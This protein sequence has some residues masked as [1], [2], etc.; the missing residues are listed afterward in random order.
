MNN[1]QAPQVGAVGGGEG[2]DD[3]D[4][5]TVQ[6]ATN[7]TDLLQTMGEAGANALPA[8]AGAIEANPILEGIPPLPVRLQEKFRHLH[9]LRIADYNRGFDFRWRFNCCAEY[10]LSAL[11]LLLGSRVEF[12]HNH[13]EERNFPLNLMDHIAYQDVKCIGSLETFDFHE[14]LTSL[15]KDQHYLVRSGTQMGAGHYAVLTC[16][17]G[18]WCAISSSSSSPVVLSENDQT[19]LENCCSLFCPKDGAAWGDG[20]ADHSILFTPVNT[21]VLADLNQQVIRQRQRQYQEQ[22]RAE[23]GPPYDEQ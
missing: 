22:Q 4:I 18:D 16:V 7:T 2:T 6:A 1:N 11:A 23:Y 10:C 9:S 19:V 14:W 13:Y 12:E 17:E 20:V 21:N 8:A 15:D 3:E 5:L